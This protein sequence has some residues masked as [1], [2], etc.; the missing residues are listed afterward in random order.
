MIKKTGKDF[1]IIII[2]AEPYDDHPLSPAG[3]IAKILDA[4]GYSIGIIDT[5]DWKKDNDFLKL[6]TPRLCFCIT[7]GSIDSM[8][9]NYTPLKRDRKE[10]PH[11]KIT[12]MPDRA[13]I[14][15]C[16]KIKQLFKET[17]IVIG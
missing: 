12:A 6:G 14:V 4:K 16:N 8:L 11:A 3:V 9:N 7:S 13:L 17:K 10:D 15:Y 2:T 5:P 1:D